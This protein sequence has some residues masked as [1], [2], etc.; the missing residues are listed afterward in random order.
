MQLAAILLLCV[1]SVQAVPLTINGTI[2]DKAS[3][4]I[5]G[6]TITLSNSDLSSTSGLQGEFSLTV[7]GNKPAETHYK[8][9]DEILVLSKENQQLTSLPL[10]QADTTISLQLDIL[11][12]QFLDRID[13]IP[14]YFQRDGAFGGFPLKGALYCGPVSV[15]N[16][17]VYL[18]RN[19]YPDLMSSSGNPKKDQHELTRILGSR[20]YINTGTNGSSPA[21]ICR[22]VRAFLNDKGYQDAKIKYYGWRQ[23]PSQ[24]RIHSLPDLEIAREA[25]FQRKAVWLNIGW[26][27][28][29]E[30]RNTYTRNGGH[31]V[32]LVGYG[33]DGKKPS[34]DCLIIHDS[35][36][37]HRLNDYIIPKK[38]AGGKMTGKV[39]GLPRDASNHYRYQVSSKKYGIIDGMIVVEMPEPNQKFPLQAKQ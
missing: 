23:V 35:E 38:I 27:N 20:Q 1:I 25:T 26:Y 24:F 39:T 31:W 29:N 28:Y 37:K 4:P 10:P 5:P 12:D 2:V 11:P 18:S 32:V 21:D 34:S 14:D 36:T 8:P 33:H 30:E 7:T 16:S 17:F 13:S 9:A 22:G 6:V 19:G 15:S 3:R